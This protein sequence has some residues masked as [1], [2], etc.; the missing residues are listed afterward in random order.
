MMD[1]QVEAKIH[2]VQT[3][4]NHNEKKSVI[5]SSMEVYLHIFSKFH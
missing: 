4:Q 3:K 1:R 2:K 5:N